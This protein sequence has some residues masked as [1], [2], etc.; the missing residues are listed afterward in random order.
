MQF[1]I[2]LHKAGTNE[3][4]WCLIKVMKISIS[5]I[6]FLFSFCSVQST[7]CQNV[8]KPE[9]TERPIICFDCDFSIKEN[10]ISLP[11]PEY[12]KAALAVNASGIVG[13]S[14][15]IDEQ[16]TVIEATAV[17]GHPLLRPAAIKAAFQAKFKPAMLSGKAVQYLSFI[18]YNFAP[19][20]SWK[21]ET[22]VDSKQTQSTKLKYEIKPISTIVGKPAKLFKPPFPLNCRCKFSKNLKVEIQFIVDE[23]GN[24]EL[25]K[26]VSGHPL[27]RQASEV[28][29]RAS[30]FYPSSVA[31][32]A[33]KASG[34]IIYDFVL[35]KK[36]LQSRIL[37]YELKIR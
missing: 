1:S 29:I 13:V 15:K 19:K 12:P 16:G 4:V 35:V 32:K 36:R 7:F 3:F 21:P 24:V 30:K 22:E 20:D 8:E 6:T 14:V 33:V 11:S 31:L 26:A 18:R 9:K 27:L 25:A 10:P 34:I 17:S 2:K 5:V 37:R 23:K 28:A